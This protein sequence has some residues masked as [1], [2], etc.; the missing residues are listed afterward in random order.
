MRVNRHQI[1]S[2]VGD[3]VRGE[4]LPKM[5]DNRAMQI[6]LTVA[7][8]AALANSKTVDA[9]LNNG[10][11]KALLED[12]G[13]GTYELESVASAMHEAIEQ[14]GSFPVRIPPVPLVSPGEI[15]LNLNA[16]DVDALRRKIESAV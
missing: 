5:S 2:G 12:D 11:V 15:T 9:M 3:Y 7:L 10:V 1:V 8:N 4:I 16:N 14:Y 6:V 13:S